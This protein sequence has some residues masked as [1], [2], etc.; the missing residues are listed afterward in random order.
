MIADCS[1]EAITVALATVP[2]IA[3]DR[4]TFDASVTNT[5]ADPCLFAGDGEDT[6]LQ[7]TSGDVRV[8]NSADCSGTAAVVGKRWVLDSG[9]AQDFQVS[10]PRS[11][12]FEGCT[13]ATG[14]PQPGA[15]WA[16]L[17]VGGVDADRVQFVM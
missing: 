15:Y 5:G 9:K 12:S 2:S 11:W 14:V 16:S 10:W 17:T 4:V 8:W 1:A 13:E 6:V 3:A 7:I